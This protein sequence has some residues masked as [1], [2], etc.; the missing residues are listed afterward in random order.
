MTDDEF[1]KICNESV[2]ML[3]ASKDVNMSFTSFK[4]KAEK[5]NCYKTNQNWNKG[6]NSISD[7][8]I[9]SKYS[10]ELFCKNSS[11]RREYIKSLIIKNNLKDYKCEECDIK[12]TWNGKNLSLHLDHKNGIRNDNRLD[13]LRF[14]C[15]NCHSQT[16]TYCVK[17]KNGNILNS[18]DKKNI[19]DCI[20]NSRTITD[21]INKLGLKD[22]KSNRINIKIIIEDE[23]IKMHL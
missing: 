22:T 13:N 4:R 5:L 7:L 2:S 1:I 14:L 10:N 21:V 9:K 6:K 17:N 18:L 15:P 16:E 12:N 11:A 3:Q 20:L 19:I 8:R 23:K